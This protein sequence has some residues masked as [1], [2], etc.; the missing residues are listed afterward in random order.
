QA[1]PAFSPADLQAFLEGRATE[2]GASG[3]D[4]AYGSG[5]L[6]LASAPNPT[7]PCSAVAL[8]SNLTSPQS[9]DTTVVFSSLATA[10]KPEFKYFTLAPA[11]GSSWQQAR[12]WG[13]PTFNWSTIG[14][15][16]GTWAVQ[17]WARRTGSIATYETWTQTGYELTPYTGPLPVANAGS[18]QSVSAGRAVAL[19][20][21]ASSEP[22]GNPL[23]YAWSQ[24]AG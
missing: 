16:T 13:G 5:K 4:N 9:V 1:N 12:D 10:C 18:D 7:G 15:A 20:G 22:G 24:L 2:L 17:V 23:A 14:L 11:N 21:S 6:W 19:D 3:K 8:T